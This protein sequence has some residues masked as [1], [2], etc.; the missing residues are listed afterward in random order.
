MFDDI[1]LKF[2]TSNT[3]FKTLKKLLRNVLSSQ[4]N[5]KKLSLKMGNQAGTILLVHL[6]PMKSFVNCHGS[7][8]MFKRKNQIPSWS[9]NRH[10]HNDVLHT[11]ILYC[12]L[13]CSTLETL[14]KR[15]K[16]REQEILQLKME[17]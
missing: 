5:F 8:R 1:V 9:C 2:K 16:T 15:V 7:I 17:K 3:V 11:A 14:L 13:P 6:Y 10:V 12:M 4:N